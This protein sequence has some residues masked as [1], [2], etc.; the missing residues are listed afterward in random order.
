MKPDGTVFTIVHHTLAEWA[1]A[2]RVQL[3][4]LGCSRGYSDRV[5]DEYLAAVPGKKKE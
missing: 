4:L 1:E 3:I 5:R 2:R